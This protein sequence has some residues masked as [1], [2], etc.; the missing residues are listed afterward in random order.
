MRRNVTEGLGPT[1]IDRFA[2]PLLARWPPAP[3][4]GRLYA[5]TSFLVDF[6]AAAAADMS[7]PTGRPPAQRRLKF[8]QRL[9]ALPPHH[10]V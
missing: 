3:S 4:T 9:P 8:L 1:V 2:S 10:T 5:A 7:A 6:A